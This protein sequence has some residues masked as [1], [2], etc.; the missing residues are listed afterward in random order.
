MNR[1]K[2]Q[3]EESRGR[4]KQEEG[5]QIKQLLF[6]QVELRTNSHLQ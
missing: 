5:K 6:Y 2:L 3:Q 4:N 1:F